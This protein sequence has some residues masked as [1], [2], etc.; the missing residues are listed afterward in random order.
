MEN[1]NRESLLTGNAE[2][3][4]EVA[5]EEEDDG[6]NSKDDEKVKTCNNET[7]LTDNAE[8]IQEVEYGEEEKSD[9]NFKGGQSDKTTAQGLKRARKSKMI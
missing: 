6:K 3:I 8:N 7:L 5:I 2:N 1:N 4:Q 9:N